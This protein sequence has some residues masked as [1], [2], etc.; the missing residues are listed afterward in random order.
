MPSDVTARRFFLLLLTATGLLLALVIKPMLS[1]LIVAAVLAGMLW[2]LQRKLAGER[3]SRRAAA[4]TVLV[5]GV[6][7]LMLGPVAGFAAFAV[8][9]SAQ[10]MK[11]LAETVRSEVATDF[12]AR[13]P[14][15]LQVTVAEALDGLSQAQSEQ[16]MSAGWA[17]VTATGEL[18]LDSALML[19]ALFL[20]L[21][22]GRAFVHWLDHVSPLR[23]GQTR[24]LLAD[25]RSV[26]SSVVTSTL[27]T[28]A[29]QTAVAL[30]GYLIASVPHPTFFAAAT[31]FCAIIPA[32]GAAS[33]CLLAALI[34]VLT[35]HP[36]MALF[37]SIWGVAV[38]GLVDNV[39]KPMLLKE[40]MHDMP[41]SVVFFALFGGLVAFGP[42]GLLL[43][44]LVVS[45]FVALLRMHER[46]FSPKARSSM[47]LPV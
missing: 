13:F 41:G 47:G 23:P 20:L 21:T 24:E 10:G 45:L 22:Q 40:G 33:V 34:L 37:L 11:F 16:A 46:D 15:P 8:N 5:L 6:V 9:E 44:P 7:V 43:G 42:I 14:A 27:L 32:I 39:V 17:A 30:G 29:V 12:L 36:Y 38:V 31:F 28:A 1:A 26:S 35:G 19:I 18:V 3:R 2:P 25:F 4:A